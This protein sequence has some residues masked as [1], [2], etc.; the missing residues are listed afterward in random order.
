MEIQEK[1][2][3]NAGEAAELLQCNRYSVRQLLRKKLLKGKKAGQGWKI[4]GRAIL[5]YL[6]K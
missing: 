4:T 5:D 6:E 3:Y 1:A 2:I